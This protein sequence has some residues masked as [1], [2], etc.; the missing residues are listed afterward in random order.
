MDEIPIFLR[1]Y[2]DNHT[3]NNRFE[4]KIQPNTSNSIELVFDTETKYDE[5]KEFVFG[6]CGIWINKKLN[7]FYIFHN[8]NLKKSEIT[9][10]QNICSKY[11]VILISRSE[12][13]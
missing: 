8:D 7:R 2:V 13:V 3:E 10:L 5:S 1:C 9:K 11:N 12:F 4:P 6:S